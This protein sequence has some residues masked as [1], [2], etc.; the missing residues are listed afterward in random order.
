M[1]VEDWIE[2]NENPEGIVTEDEVLWDK[3]YGEIKGD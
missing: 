1:N 3:N 2:I